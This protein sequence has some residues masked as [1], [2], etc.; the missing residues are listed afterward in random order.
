MEIDQMTPFLIQPISAAVLV[1]FAFVAPA[2]AQES[3]AKTA[4][5]DLR[6]FAR[7]Q[8]VMIATQGVTDYGSSLIAQNVRIYHEED[9]NAVVIT[10]PEMRIE[11][12][13]TALALIPAAEFLITLH[14]DRRTEYLLAVSH[15]GEIVADVSDDQILLDFPFETLAIS[16]IHAMRRA[17][18]LD[19]SLDLSFDGL[20][21]HIDL[22]RVGDA[23]IRI[24]ADT[25]RYSF[26]MSDDSAGNPSRQV[27]EAEIN[28]LSLEFTGHE[29]DMLSDEPGMLRQAF[30][31]GLF[32]HFA[33]SA[34]SSTGT[35]EQTLDGN[36]ISVTS[37]AGPSALNIDI[38]DGGASAE[39]MTGAGHFSGGMAPFVGDISFD[40]VSLS[41]GGPLIATPDDQTFYYRFNFENIVASPET[42]AIVGAEE[43]GGEG[44]TVALDVS[45]QGRL[46]QDLG[47]E[48]GEG[49]TP[50]I[51]ITTV[52]LNRL[53]TR[54][55]DAELS[56][57]GTFAFLGGLMASIGQDLP[58]GTGDFVFELIGGD[59]FLTRLNALGIVPPDQQFFARMM[60]NGL[61]RPVGEDHLRSEVAIRPGGVI[62]VNDA[63]LPF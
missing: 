21:A 50:P 33:L 15:N 34:Q 58:N 23:D 1:V 40:E 7:Q 2:V 25:T 47:V 44:I 62:T 56:G 5:D 30:D 22:Q 45:A 20:N 31:A 54:V 46:T 37:T 42:L 39:S 3:A 29:L 24:A 59:A 27:G 18:A 13:G 8:G 14:P 38:A 16:T 57:A 61:G 52:S 6:N 26:V 32:A 36:V 28:G 4:W 60:M 51:D 9:P 19:H 11:P 55:G 12:R 43:F 17:T 10:M 41:L 49:D 48:F 53:L 35:S 63:P